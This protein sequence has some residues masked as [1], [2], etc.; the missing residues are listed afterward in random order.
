VSG[1]V[2]GSGL[3][4]RS[5]MGQVRPGADGLEAQTAA[6]FEVAFVDQ[7]GT[8]SQEPLVVCWG[9]PFEWCRP[10]RSFLSYRGRRSFSG[11]WWFSG[12]G[13]HVGYE[14]WL[15]RDHLM[16]LDADAEVVAVASQPFWLSWPGGQR[17]VR[18]AP[19]FFVRLSD[20]T[21]VVIDV[22]PDDRIEP[23]DAAKFEASAWACASVGWKYRRVGGLPPVLAANLRWLSGYRHPRCDDAVLAARLLDTFARRAALMVGAARVGDPIAVL[24][25]LFHLLWRGRLL[26]DLTT[27]LGPDSV[28]RAADGS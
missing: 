27:P 1:A 13:L 17:R 26:A 19:D 20:G 22:R 15:E 23:D 21:G 8:A 10:V 16:A 2:S 24:P 7:G 4:V 28:V 3:F 6:E 9:E 18:H 5:G 11:L 12:T 14:S 25:V